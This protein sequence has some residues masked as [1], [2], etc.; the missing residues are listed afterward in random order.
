MT[1]LRRHNLTENFLLLWLLKSFYP[2]LWNDLWEWE[3]FN[4][5]IE[6]KFHNPTFWLV[7]VFMDWRKYMRPQPYTM[8]YSE[9]KNAEGKIYS[10]PQGKEDQLV[11]QCK[12]VNFETYIQVTYI[13]RRI[14]IYILQRMSWIHE[15][16]RQQ[17]V[18]Y[19]LPNGQL[20]KHTYK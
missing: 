2:L 6:T 19:P 1:F 13:L 11:T 18:C 10:L 16:E 4:R 14:Y 9:L 17:S 8:N 15:F 7:V 20:W 12:M 3:S 5:D